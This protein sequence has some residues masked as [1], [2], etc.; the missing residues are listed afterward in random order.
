M[1]PKQYRKALDELGL[2]QVE[3]AKL[4][5]VNPRTSRRYALGERSIPKPVELLL[6]R[7]VDEER[8]NKRALLELTGDEALKL[9]DDEL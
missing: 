3:A 2:S 7:L 6:K 4:L 5:G 9:L 1:T 8:S